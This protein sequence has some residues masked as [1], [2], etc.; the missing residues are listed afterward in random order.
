[1]SEFRKKPKVDQFQATK[2]QYKKNDKDGQVV[3]NI[4]G[5]TERVEHSL[6]FKELYQRLVASKKVYTCCKYQVFNDQFHLPKILI[7]WV[8]SIIWI[9][10]IIYLNNINMSHNHA[11]SANNSTHCTVQ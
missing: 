3:E 11:I 6:T 10:Q 4:S 9:F 8:K 2:K 5:K 7:K 1:M